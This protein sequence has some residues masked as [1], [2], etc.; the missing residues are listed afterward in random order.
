M[1]EK[2]VQ[3]SLSDK[4]RPHG[5]VNFAFGCFFY[6]SLGVPLLF[7]LR[8]ATPGSIYALMIIVF[9]LFS[10]LSAAT[11]GVILAC[12][13]K[14]I[15]P[16]SAMAIVTFIFFASNIWIDWMREFDVIYLLYPLIGMVL[17]AMCFFITRRYSSLRFS[18]LHSF[19]IS[20]GT[21]A[22][23]QV[24]LAYFFLAWFSIIYPIWRAILI[25]GSFGSFILRPLNL[26]TWVI[27][28]TGVYLSYRWARMRELLVLC[29]IILFTTAIYVWFNEDNTVYIA[30]SLQFFSSTILCGRWLL[31]LRFKQNVTESDAD[32]LLW[33]HY[34]P[35][36]ETKFITSRV[37]FKKLVDKN[38]KEAFLLSLRRRKIISNIIMLIQIISIAVAA[39]LLI[40]TISNELVR[41]SISYAEEIEFESPL[42]GLHF[43]LFSYIF[44]ESYAKFF[45]LP[46]IFTIPI[47]ILLS[48]TW[49]TPSRILLLRPFHRGHESHKLKKLIRSEVANFGHVYTL[50]DT[51]INVPWYVTL[52]LILGQLSFFTFRYREIR[53]PDH[54]HRLLRS[55]GR[56]KIRNIN[57]ALSPNKVF[58]VATTNF[59]W[60]HVVQ[61]FLLNVDIIIIDLS[62]LKV[63]V[64]KEFELCADLGLLDRVI[65]VVDE[66]Q[67]MVVEEKLSD[68][69]KFEN[70]K[71]FR[72]RSGSVLEHKEFKLR[73]LSALI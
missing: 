24:D 15:R 41:L 19:L 37:N 4:S 57:W 16:L 70:I 20:T 54:L 69:N 22:R 67:S 64:V 11:I 50:S 56:R 8:E 17:C 66:Q 29:L 49:K 52:P 21:S 7:I 10:I 47:T 63:G 40:F 27:L 13:W 30:F 45:I 2:I 6:S 44:R 55:M 26:I 68:N 65:C 53:S 42:A 43:P 14:R 73:L 71:I 59:A 33:Q 9:L 72:Y 62:D 60:V 61:R 38:N 58:P 48:M 39:I 3:D 28:A 25:Q 32:R 1:S 5:Q 46:F 36:D 18:Q 23:K 35:S 12:L 34:Q 51:D 31:F